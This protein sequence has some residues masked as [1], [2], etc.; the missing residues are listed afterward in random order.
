M[1]F[2]SRED[3]DLP[4]GV[5]NK[6]LEEAANTARKEL[7][8]LYGPPVVSNEPNTGGIG[9]AEGVHNYVSESDRL[10]DDVTTL[11]AGDFAEDLKIATLEGNSNY[12]NQFRAEIKGHR[13]EKLQ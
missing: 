1:G 11:L 7:G 13:Q 5:N 4:E 8:S 2:L 10:P 12:I 6:Q 3:I 9:R